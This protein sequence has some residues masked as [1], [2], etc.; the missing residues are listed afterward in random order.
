MNAAGVISFDMTSC[1][2]DVM[3]DAGHMAVLGDIYY[4]TTTTALSA[5]ATK[6]L[7]HG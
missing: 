3:P 7:T 4:S 5:T 6:Q 1:A 2:D